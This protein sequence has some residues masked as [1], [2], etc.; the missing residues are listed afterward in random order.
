M[1]NTMFY[2]SM[3][4]TTE[5]ILAVVAVLVL[6][7]GNISKL[8]QSLGSGIRNFRQSMQGDD[9]VAQ[10]EAKKIEEKEEGKDAQGGE[11]KS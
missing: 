3:L 6:F 11:N 8:G 2:F 4:G 7:P 10:D 9:Q 5:M 1:L